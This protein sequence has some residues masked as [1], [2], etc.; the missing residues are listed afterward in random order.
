MRITLDVEPLDSTALDAERMFN[1]FVNQDLPFKILDDLV[2]VGDK[3]TIV[4]LIDCSRLDMGIDHLPLVSPVF[5]NRF[6]TMN[7]RS[8]HAVRPRHVI[9]EQGKDGFHVPIVE[10]IVKL[11]DCFFVMIHSRAPFCHRWRGELI[12]LTVGVNHV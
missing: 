5:P 11:P 8:I 3:R 12:N 10:S 9:G 1:R 2:N 4:G 6:F 7:M